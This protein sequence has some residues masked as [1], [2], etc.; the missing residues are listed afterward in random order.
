MR[1]DGV[2]LTGVLSTDL[3]ALCEHERLPLIIVKPLRPRYAVT[4]SVCVWF[5]FYLF[6]VV[7]QWRTVLGRQ[8]RRTLHHQNLLCWQIGRTRTTPP[9]YTHYTCE[10]RHH[11]HTHTPIKKLM[12]KKFLNRLALEWKDTVYTNRSIVQ[13]HTTTRAQVR[14]PVDCYH[15][16]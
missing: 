2:K 3:V 12:K 6:S 11:T 14:K 15:C 5:Y 8:W 9:H 10:V 1:A 7:S 13:L 4:L 16:L